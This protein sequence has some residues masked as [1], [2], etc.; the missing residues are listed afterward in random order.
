MWLVLS[1][2]AERPPPEQDSPLPTAFIPFTMRATAREGRLQT[3]R[4]DIERITANR[5]GRTPLSMI[6]ATNTAACL[7]GAIAEGEHTASAASLARYLAD[8]LSTKDIHL[9]ITVSMDR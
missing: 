8:G 4:T 3:F 9:D 1:S 7:R 6:T 2:G 5:S